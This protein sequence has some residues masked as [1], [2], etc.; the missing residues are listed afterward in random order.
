[1][2]GL[3]FLA[4][5]ISFYVLLIVGTVIMASMAFGLD[6]VNGQMAVIFI[7]VAGVPGAYKIAS[8]NR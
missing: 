8:S 5:F 6:T 3:G 7:L 2:Q 4:R 1:M